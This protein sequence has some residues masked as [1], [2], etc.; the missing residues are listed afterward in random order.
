MNRELKFNSSSS[1]VSC[2][3]VDVIDDS[4]VE[5]QEVFLLQLFSSDS[6]LLILS[7]NVTVTIE[8]NDCMFIIIYC[9]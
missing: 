9:F 7:S 2:Y 3:D 8:D 1:N 6:A 5:S 4:I